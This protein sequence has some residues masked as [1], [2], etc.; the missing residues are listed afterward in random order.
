MSYTRETHAHGPRLPCVDTVVSGP[1]V[2]KVKQFC[3]FQLE[4][5]VFEP[6]KYWQA[7]QTR[8]ILILSENTPDAYILKISSSRQ[9]AILQKLKIMTETT[10]LRLKSVV[11]VIL[12][13]I[14]FLA[15]PIANKR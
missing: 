11:Y 2:D 4:G 8:L 6:N 7:L 14:L 5:S 3:L 15:A 1:L 13:S 9:P 10:L 12:A